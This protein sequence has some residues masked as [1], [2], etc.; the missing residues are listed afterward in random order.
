MV[1]AAKV[2]LI[3]LEI[4]LMVMPH[5]CIDTG[6]TETH[7]GGKAAF[8]KPHLGPDHFPAPPTRLRTVGWLALIYGLCPLA[9]S[10]E[11]L[12]S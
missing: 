2:K 8:S 3:Q 1:S 9:F 5:Y 7:R 12:S 11:C 10:L 4:V 6:P